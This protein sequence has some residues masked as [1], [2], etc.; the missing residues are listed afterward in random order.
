MSPTNF[1]R[2][3]AELVTALVN[4]GALTSGEAAE[5]KPWIE[6]QA[7]DRNGSRIHYNARP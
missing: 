1:G 6:V 3:Y 4:A 7:Y 5:L 2:G